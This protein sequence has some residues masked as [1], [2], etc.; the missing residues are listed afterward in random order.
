[1][2]KKRKVVI[3]GAAGR[4]FHDFNV[5]FRQD[6]DVEVVAF[7][8]TQ[9]PNI[10]GRVYPAAL[11]G[12]AYPNGIPIHPE[13]ELE[14]LVREHDVDDVVFAYSDVAYEDLMH[15]A[16]RALAA[17][18]DFRLLGPKATLLESTKPVL[19][20]CAV[21]TGVGKSPT[22][23][24]VASILRDAGLSIAVLRHPM[25]YG[26]LA[27]QAVQRFA[28]LEDMKAADCTIEEMEEYE[29]H[30]EAGNVVFAGVDYERILREA[31]K[32]ADVILWDGGNND[33]PFVRSDLQIVLV[34][35]HRPGDESR[36]FPGETNL[37]SA[38]VVIL[39]K[40]G[41]ADPKNVDAVRASA[42]AANPTAMLVEADLALSVDAPERLKGARVLVIEDGPTTTHGGMA[43]GAG[44]VAARQ[45]G[46][47]QLVDPRPSAVGSLA[48]TLRHYSHLTEVLPAMGYGAEQ[49]RELE[50]SI[51]ATDCD[52][53]VIATPVDLR[54]MMK[55]DKPT[56][57]VTYRT[58]ERGSPTLDDA[59]A[60][61][62]AKAKGG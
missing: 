2:A 8:A 38:D 19:S 17:G 49:V 41:T 58:A 11:A 29:P 52:A 37:L 23:R 30:V 18:A 56:V 7:T 61:F 5:A 55:I 28:S 1:M 53:V 40:V 62:I 6:A 59:L 16:A 50:A 20:V 36:Y 33:L 9:I 44:A 45:G 35:P 31:E 27:K 3:L 39:S 10:E 43:Y 46:A 48:D 21:R 22:T 57:R 14:K 42:R 54:R 47:R 13:S 26:D 25:P 24:R 4:D 34:D 32:E 60:P 51:A 12:P 15:R